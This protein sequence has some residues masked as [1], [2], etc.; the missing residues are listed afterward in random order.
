[1]K[2]SSVFAVSVAIVFA[3][4]GLAPAHAAD[5][6]PQVVV[7]PWGDWLKELIV[8]VGGVAVTLASFLVAKFVPS[9]LRLF[10]TDGMV[11]N[12]VNTALAQVEGAVAGQKLPLPIAN[13]VV[14]EA[15]SYIV[16]SEPK[17]A[18]W[19][20]DKL[21][22]LVLAKLSALGCAPVSAIG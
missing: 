15:V 19:L 14:A 4:L 6:A 5:A 1:M 17:V 8:A 2:F 22:P 11:T 16:A 7:I 10:I 21:K 3:L 18:K 12:A 9:Y 13:A 20:G